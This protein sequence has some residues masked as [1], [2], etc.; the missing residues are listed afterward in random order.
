MLAS[1]VKCL[2]TLKGAQQSHNASPNKLKEE[3]PSTHLSNKACKRGVKK[4]CCPASCTIF[5]SVHMRN[6]EEE[7]CVFIYLYIYVYKACMGNAVRTFT[8][9]F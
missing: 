8:H 3:E 2:E 4:N 6:G 1:S 9:S 5:L 7:M